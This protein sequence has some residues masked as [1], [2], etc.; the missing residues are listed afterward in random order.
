MH[1]GDGQS[2]TVAVQRGGP[3]GMTSAVGIVALGRARVGEI[4]PVGLGALLMSGRTVAEGHARLPFPNIQSIF[5]NNFQCSKLKNTKY[6]L[7]YAKKFLNLA[8]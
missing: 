4:W 6:I 1:V 2:A 8:C 7:P 5:P 3:V